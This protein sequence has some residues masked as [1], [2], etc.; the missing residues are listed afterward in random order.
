[1][2]AAFVFCLFLFTI[3]NSAFSQTYWIPKTPIWDSLYNWK[4]SISEVAKVI[5]QQTILP[6]YLQKSPTSQIIVKSNKGL[7]ILVEGTGQVYQATQQTSKKLAFTRIDSTTYF[8]YNF[9]A[10]NFSYHDTLFSYGGMGYWLTN[11]HLRYF[12]VGKEWNVFELAAVYPS[13]R[14]VYNYLPK[15]SKL[16]FVQSI[17]NKKLGNYNEDPENSVIELDLATKRSHVLGK[18]NANLLA[19]QSLP[20][21]WPLNVSFNIESL[22]GI[23]TFGINSIYLL[24]FGDNTVYKLVNKSIINQFFFSSND[25]FSNIFERNGSIYYTANTDS[26]V[27][28]FPISLRDFVKEPYTLY[29]PIHTNKPIYYT[30]GGMLLMGLAFWG[31]LLN[32]RKRKASDPIFIDAIAAIDAIETISVTDFNGVE[33]ALIA[34]IIAKAE[35]GENFTVFEMNNVLG[36]NKKSIEIQKKVRTETINRINH[37]YQ[38]KYKVETELIER[39]R[40]DD[41]R[42]FYRYTISIENRQLIA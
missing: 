31:I 14:F 10:I 24:R 17:L 30:M 19:I 27:H 15:Q 1:M 16:Y 11:G 26:A 7:Y 13:I 4:G 2:K 6:I 29:E 42:R 23:L 22:Q 34:Q 20:T 40:S 37:K 9:S 18:F 32:R 39:I 33:K 21:N 36:L 3:P 25:N 38:V 41:D 5:S 35:T 28:H 12:N 8:G